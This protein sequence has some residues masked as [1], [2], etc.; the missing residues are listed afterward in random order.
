MT[1]FH[2]K[3]FLII[4]AGG[5]N[6]GGLPAPD[7]LNGELRNHLDSIFSGFQKLISGTSQVKSVEES[8]VRMHNF[9]HSIDIQNYQTKDKAI[10]VPLAYYFHLSTK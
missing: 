5:V 10:D 3:L 6:G 4:V 1:V 9:A 8:N 7:K 2:T